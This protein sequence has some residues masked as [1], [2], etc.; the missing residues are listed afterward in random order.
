MREAIYENIENSSFNEIHFVV[1]ENKA[2]KP[3]LI[4]IICIWLNQN[5]LDP[6]SLNF[7]FKKYICA[8]SLFAAENFIIEV[9]ILLC[10]CDFGASAR[11]LFLILLIMNVGQ[12]IMNHPYYEC[13]ALSYFSSILYILRKVFLIILIINFTQSLTYRLYH[14]C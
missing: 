8:E 6:L 1:E 3:L 2:S 12:S 14:K 11:Q 5:L 7:C 10:M 13:K 4:F 9:S